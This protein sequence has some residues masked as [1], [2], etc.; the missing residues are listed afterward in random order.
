[1]FAQE[2][3]YKNDDTIP[4]TY[5]DI[6]KATECSGKIKI[7]LYTDFKKPDLNEFQSLLKTNSNPKLEVARLLSGK[8][9]V[10]L[11]G[12]DG[13][14][15]GKRHINFLKKEANLRTSPFLVC[16]EKSDTFL[17]EPLLTSEKDVEDSVKFTSQVNQIVLNGNKLGVYKTDYINDKPILASE[18]ANTIRYNYDIDLGKYISKPY[19]VIPGMFIELDDREQSINLILD[20]EPEEPSS[21]KQLKS[22]ENGNV[23]N[24]SNYWMNYSSNINNNYSFTGGLNNYLSFERST[25]VSKLSFYDYDSRSEVALDSLYLESIGEE[26]PMIYS[27]GKIQG[28]SSQI[29]GVGIEYNRRLLNDDSFLYTPPISFTTGGPAYVELYQGNQLISS[30]STSGGESKIES[31]Q[32]VNTNDLTLV[33]SELGLKKKYIN[34]PYDYSNNMASL[35]KSGSYEWGAKLGL[36]ESNEDLVVEYEGVRG[37][38]YYSVSLNGYYSTSDRQLNLSVKSMMFGLNNDLLFGYDKTWGSYAGIYISTGKG[39]NLYSKYYKNDNYQLNASYNRNGVILS[40]DN[41]LINLSNNSSE[42]YLN[43]VSIDYSIPNKLG[44]LTLN[45]TNSSDDNEYLG[46]TMSFDLEKLQWYGDVSNRGYYARASYTSDDR[47]KGL[48]VSV[49]KDNSRIGKIKSADAWL[50]TED[51]NLNVGYSKSDHFETTSMSL[52]GGILYSKNSLY[53]TSLKTP[54]LMI[55]E[56]NSTTLSARNVPNDSGVLIVPLNSHFASET[57]SLTEGSVDKSL[58]DSDVLNVTP[59]PNGIYHFDVKVNLIKYLVG[60]VE[61]HSRKTLKGM[62]VHLGDKVF[63]IGPDGLISNEFVLEPGQDEVLLIIPDLN[64][65]Y[66]LPIDSDK[67]VIDFGTLKCADYSIL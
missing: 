32:Y 22:F 51:T 8:W 60:Y 30:M 57:V 37:F 62:E 16:Y 67:L 47:D 12:Y 41:L 14:D 4:V 35:Y 17:R 24:Y 31:Y 11:S 20:I 54:T 43:Q 19:E 52:S 5:W 40:D 29:Y 21:K 7:S 42:I 2:I 66:P 9:R 33:I 49:R 23:A 36:S 39:F 3:E 26:G 34:I 55:L 59:K 18:V 50:N 27:V 46:L 48:S 64:C 53:L 10:Y 38:D 1:M 28:N 63:Y 58:G 25:V 56:S 13:M 6:S 15:E 65:E 44:S 61:S 45:Y